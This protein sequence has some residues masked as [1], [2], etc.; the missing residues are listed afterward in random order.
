MFSHDRLYAYS[1]Y[2]VVH[3]VLTLD[4]ALRLL[5]FHGRTRNCRAIPRRLPGV[6]EENKNVD[7][8]FVLAA[9]IFDES[10]AVSHTGIV[11]PTQYHA[12]Y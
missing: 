12:R 6:Q 2:F 3:M 10:A 8:L 7:S 11:A 1:K 4:A 9:L 5:C